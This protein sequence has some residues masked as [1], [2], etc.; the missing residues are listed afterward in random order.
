MSALAFSFQLN[1]SCKKVIKQETNVKIVNVNVSIVYV[2]PS[3]RHCASNHVCNRFPGAH[4]WHTHCVTDGHKCAVDSDCPYKGTYCVYARCTRLH[5]NCYRDGDC[6]FYPMTACDRGRCVK[7]QSQSSPTFQCR[8]SNEC[9]RFPGTFCVSNQ[10]LRLDQISCDRDRDCPVGTV[11][12][13]NRCAERQTTSPPRCSSNFDCRWHPGTL[14]VNRQCVNPGDIVCHTNQDCPEGTECISSRCSQTQS[15]G[16]QRCTTNSDCRRYPGTLCVNN[17]CVRPETIEC[18]H[19]WNCPAGT[20]CLNKKCTLQQTS[21]RECSNDLDCRAYP[22]TYCVDS[23]CKKPGDISCRSDSNCPSGTYCVNNR[24]TKLGQKCSRDQDCP[25]YPQTACINSLCA[26]VGQSCIRDEDCPNRPY[27]ACIASRCEKVRLPVL[28]QN[29]MRE[30]SVCESYSYYY[31]NNTTDNY[32]AHDNN[33]EN[34]ETNTANNNAS[35]RSQVALGKWPNGQR[36]PPLPQASNMRRMKWDN[37]LE[38]SATARAR[39]CNL[40]L[41]Q[42]HLNENLHVATLQPSFVM[43][44]DEAVTDWFDEIKADGINRRVM[45]HIHL[46]NKPTACRGFLKTDD[47][48]L[49]VPGL[50][51]KVLDGCFRCER[52]G[53]VRADRYPSP[54]QF[55][56]PG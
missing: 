7:A 45:Y 6:P 54:S 4:C 2:L 49:D 20:I 11:C 55:T 3:N 12:S 30:Q 16:S 39:L 48:A 47:V 10:C 52:V 23:T 17:V 21:G 43:A 37:S 8:S 32:V 29:E 44:A 14:C 9:R 36:N 34:H 24:C 5:Q 42:V 56:Q 50:H 31:N 13:E 27:T 33:K 26:K 1:G 25:L 28:P 15:S 38:N 18:E 46:H 19:K 35:S 40:N 41:A 51:R 22:G 53:V